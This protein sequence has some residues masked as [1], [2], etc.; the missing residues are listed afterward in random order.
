MSLDISQDINGETGSTLENEFQ[1]PPTLE[2]DNSNTG[3]ENNIA[4]LEQS[5]ASNTSITSTSLMLNGNTSTSL[6]SEDTIFALAEVKIHSA[7]E[8][9]TQSTSMNKH[10]ESASR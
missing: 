4:E 7:S 1:N 8:N 10:T 5:S 6:M 3:E 9:D 2:N